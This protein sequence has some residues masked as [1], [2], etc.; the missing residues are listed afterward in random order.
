MI[1]P[2]PL[3]LL[4]AAPPGGIIEHLLV[5]D[6]N[7]NFRMNDQKLARALQQLARGGVGEGGVSLPLQRYTM[8]RPA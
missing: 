3:S 2:L 7:R 5:T 6:E 1:R 4:N 8:S